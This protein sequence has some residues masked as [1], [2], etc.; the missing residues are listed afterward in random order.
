MMDHRD[1]NETESCEYKLRYIITGKVDDEFRQ[2][3]T[4]R[5]WVCG[6]R[7]KYR[8]LSSE[9]LSTSMVSIRL[10][11][12]SL[13]YF[14]TVVSMKLDCWF[15]CNSDRGSF[16]NTCPHLTYFIGFARVCEMRGE[17]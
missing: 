10:N 15:F 8:L 11:R 3:S 9:V 12:P 13:L 1:I 14:C 4:R 17:A 6:V 2:Q 5:C 7:G 16:R